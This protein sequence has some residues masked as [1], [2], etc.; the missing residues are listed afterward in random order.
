[1]WSYISISFACIRLKC[2]IGWFIDL[3]FN[4]KLSENLGTQYFKRL[5]TV[6]GVPFAEFLV[7]LYHHKDNY[8]IYNYTTMS[9]DV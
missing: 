7:F 9:L 3:D 8:G 1:M 6:H 4:K 2:S 5:Y